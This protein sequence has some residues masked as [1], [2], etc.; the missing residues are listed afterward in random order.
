L[1][2]TT[3]VYA[4][5]VRPQ[6]L[7]LGQLGRSR[8]FSARG[9]WQLSQ[10]LAVGIFKALHILYPDFADRWIRLPNSNPLFGGRPPIE[11]MTADG[12]MDGLYRVRRLLDA[13]RGGWN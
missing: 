9:C 10:V 3:L 13:R 5:K 12:G 8:L 7:S 11:W 1:L 4:E 2:G 6:F